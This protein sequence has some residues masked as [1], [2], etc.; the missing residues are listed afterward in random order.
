MP[1]SKIEH[2]KSEI[3]NAVLFDL[4]DTLLEFGD[5]ST[6]RAF[7]EGARTTYAFLRDHNQPVSCF[8]WYFLRN[9]VRLRTQY[10]I[11]IL[12]RRDFDSLE[13]LKE[14]GAKLGV[15]LSADQWTEFAWLW[16]EPLSRRAR[17]EEGLPESLARL[18]DMGL[19]L[20]IVSNTFVNRASLQ[21][22][23]QLLGLLEFFP[24]QLYSYEF[25]VRKPSTEIFRIAAG[26][27]AERPE[28]ILFVGDRID[29]DI[30]PALA[31]GM[32]AVLKE[33]Y[34]NQGKRVPPAALRIGRLAELPAL[35]EQINASAT[36]AASTQS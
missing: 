9:L 16:Y 26:R 24:V 4:G 10:L 3:I 30:L 23:L 17:I 33:A 13:V 15:R 31:S 20:G 36:E 12:T 34:T 18:T 8:A 7:L 5:F 6:T 21:R 19:K 29:N 11:A 25:H 1:E 32:R 28:N 2:Q 14:V 22:Q 27:I 35:I